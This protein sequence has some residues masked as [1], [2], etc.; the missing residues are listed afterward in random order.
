MELVRLI[1]AIDLI[2]QPL[3]LGHANR[4][5]SGYVWREGRSQVDE[6]V[7]RKTTERPLIICATR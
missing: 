6:F 5:R 1:R 7:G 2:I 4:T 3:S